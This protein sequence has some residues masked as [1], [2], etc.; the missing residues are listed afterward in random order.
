M[1]VAYL[2]CPEKQMLTSVTL[3]SSVDRAWE[4]IAAILQGAAVLDANGI[5]TP[6]TVPGN[7]VYTY[8]APGGKG[9][10]AAL[11][12]DEDDG[13]PGASFPEH[14]SIKRTLINGKAF[15]GKIIWWQYCGTYT[16]D[17][18]VNAANALEFL[19]T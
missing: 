7:L 2:Y 19:S 8:R 11:W 17:V 18:D 4:Q 13:L 5:I 3:D 10:I 16:V 1:S 15:R 6:P 14:I 12:C 9:R